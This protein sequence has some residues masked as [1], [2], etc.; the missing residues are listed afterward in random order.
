MATFDAETFLKVTGETGTGFFD[1]VGMSFGLP[2]C[3]LN[4]FDDLNVAALLPSNMLVDMDAV[5]QDAK[6]KA[7][8]ATAW[9]WNG[10]VRQVA[11]NLLHLLSGLAWIMMIPRP[12]TI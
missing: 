9:L 1:A 6:D 5:M 2:S 8:D 4:I 10:T 7:D 12:I 3:M 11:L